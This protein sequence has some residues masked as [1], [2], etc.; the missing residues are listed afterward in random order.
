M[1]E[2][3][4]EE[5]EGEEEE[6]EEGEEEEEEPR[7]A[8]RHQTVKGEKG[9]GKGEDQVREQAVLMLCADLTRA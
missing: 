4:E 7:T 2:E 5:E 8:A 1:E 9:E 3:E 6:E